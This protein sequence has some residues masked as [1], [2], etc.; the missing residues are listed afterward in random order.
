MRS[1]TA[2][3]L[4]APMYLFACII[5]GGNAQSIWQ[6]MILQLAGLAIIAWAAAASP[7][8]LPRSAKALLIIAMAFVGVVALQA[9]PL[10][11]SVFADG[12]RAR[13]ASDYRLL[14]STTQTA[15]V[16]LSP[17]G[18][19][20][21]FLAVVP[22]LA[23]FCAMARQEAYRVS[24]LIA[25]LLA[26]IAALI[27][28]SVLQ[29]AGGNGSRSYLTAGDW[30]ARPS[31]MVDLLI[32]AVPFLFI[33]AS[34]PSGRNFRRYAVL[35]IVGTAVGGLLVAG[36]FFPNAIAAYALVIPVLAASALTL[37]FPG[38][39]SRRW[40]ILLVAISAA[41][42]LAALSLTPLAGNVAGHEVSG[43]KQSRGQ[44]LATTGRAIADL[45]P[46]GS[47]L[48][49]FVR[50]YPLYARPGAVSPDPIVH[51]YNDYAEVALELGLPGIALT[52]AFL[53]WWAMAVW[54]VWRSA[55]GVSFGQ[56][57]SIASAAVL[58]HSLF[59]FPLRTPAVSVAFAMCLG[60]LV[61]RPTRA[62]RKDLRPT[63]HVVIA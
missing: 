28:L 31:H 10:P 41:G 62:P 22:P 12:V 56:A 40:L 1:S 46:L 30:M 14:G 33:V 16:S 53:I 20:A 55:D 6:N 48:G 52:A 36:F 42:S 15:P 8:A 27:T 49:S 45:A 2:R 51:A 37:T 24:W 3:H 4:V 44:I 47:G 5:L 59:D 39:R 32:V 60:L 9:I 58:A 17:F 63:R 61:A 29:I 57:A 11:L 21:A 7:G 13:I 19:L 43:S 35:G 18:S 26:G 50:V 34:N 38:S 54:P 25:A 23:I